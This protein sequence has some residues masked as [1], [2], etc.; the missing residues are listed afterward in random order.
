[1]SLDD[2]FETK[3]TSRELFIATNIV[4]KLPKETQDAAKEKTHAI[5]NSYAGRDID[6]LSVLGY[7]AE[8][9]KF[10]EFVKKLESHHETNLRYV[11]PGARRILTVPGAQRA[12]LF[13]LNCYKELGIEPKE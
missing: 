13:F 2:Q 11:H 3:K 1:M 8:Q 10:D 7:A 9:N 4:G 5:L 6:A 12:E